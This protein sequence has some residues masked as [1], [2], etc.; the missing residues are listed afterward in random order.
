MQLSEISHNNQQLTYS[1]LFTLLRTDNPSAS[2]ALCPEV[3]RIEL[4]HCSE[5]IEATT[6]RSGLRFELAN[7]K[8]MALQPLDYSLLT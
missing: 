2:H 7:E 4:K 8:L 3:R 6:T 5:V 1:K